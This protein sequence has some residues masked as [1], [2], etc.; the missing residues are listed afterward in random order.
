MAGLRTIVAMRT[1][2]T[3]HP[4]ESYPGLR[5]V[6]PGPGWPWC[7][8]PAEGQVVVARGGEAAEEYE[9]ADGLRA[10]GFE[11]LGGDRA[12]IVRSGLPGALVEWRVESPA[13]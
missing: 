5:V 7:I 4:P 8:V 11:L 6:R 10:Q 3:P 9:T 12:Q 1:L 13:G 2:T